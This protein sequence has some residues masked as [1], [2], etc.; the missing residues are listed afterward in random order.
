MWVS[1]AYHK[2]NQ[3][4]RLFAF[5]INTN[6][7]LSIYQKTDTNFFHILYKIILKEETS[8]LALNLLIQ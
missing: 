1:E 4:R 6:L 8:N 2:L 7:R 3:T 5:Q